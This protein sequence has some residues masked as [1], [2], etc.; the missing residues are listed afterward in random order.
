MEAR[1]D[2]ERQWVEARG[3]RERESKAREAWGGKGK[4]LAKKNRRGKGL[5]K[6]VKR[7]VEGKKGALRRRR[8]GWQEGSGLQVD[9]GI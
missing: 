2:T 1:A 9:G 8:R 6:G 4:G 5:G 7:K 3:E